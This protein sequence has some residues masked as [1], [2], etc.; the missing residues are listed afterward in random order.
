MLLLIYSRSWSC[1]F[2]WRPARP[3]RANTQKRCP[4]HH[5]G[6]EWKS[7]E[8]REYSITCTPVTWSNRQV[9][10]WSTKW[11][12]AKADRVLPRERTSLSKYPLPTTQEMSPPIDITR[13]SILKSDWLYSLQLKMQKLYTVSKNKTWSWLWLR[14]WTPYC[15]IQT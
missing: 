11:S 1:T 14:S 8:S 4:S 9:W 6:L 7:R 12:R 10:P 3:S 13:C 15:Q 5:R 2:L